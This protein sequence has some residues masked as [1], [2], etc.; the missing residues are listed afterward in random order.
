MPLLVEARPEGNLNRAAPGRKSQQLLSFDPLQ[1]RAAVR[2]GAG[3][4]G[5]A[6]A[7]RHYLTEWSVNLAAGRGRGRTPSGGPAVVR[8]AWVRLRRVAI[9]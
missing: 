3:G 1:R 6:A 8:V 2:G 5:P 4:A 7:G 9:T